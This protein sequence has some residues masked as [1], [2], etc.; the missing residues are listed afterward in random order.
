M[1]APGAYASRRSA[2]SCGRNSVGG[3]DAF[4]LVERRQDRIV[5]PD[6]RDRPR[7]HHQLAGQRDGARRQ[8]LVEDRARPDL[9]PVVI[10][11]VDPEDRDRGHAVL[12]RDLLGELERRQRL[13]QRVERPAEEPGLLAGDDG[14]RR[15]RRALRRFDGARRG[16][17]APLLRGDDRGDVR[18]AAGRAP[19]RADRVRPGG[20]VGRIAGKKRRDRG[21]VV[22]VVGGE[23]PDPGKPADV[24]RDSQRRF[25]CG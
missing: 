4:E 7:V 11:R 6:R 5:E 18:R 17:A 10:F 23:A 15:G 12:A 25:A 22:R 20:A 3:S 2:I 19:A 1:P 24:D 16:A 13:E 9:V 21:K 14:D 8:R